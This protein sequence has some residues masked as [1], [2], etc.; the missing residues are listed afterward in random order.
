MNVSI[1]R[2]ATGVDLRTGVH[3]SSV[4]IELPTGDVI[5]CAISEEDFSRVEKAFSTAA[6]IHEPSPAPNGNGRAVAQ[7]AIVFGGDYHPGTPDAEEEDIPE[8]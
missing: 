8:G 1:I 2:V 6:A 4:S 7:P 5:V 3:T